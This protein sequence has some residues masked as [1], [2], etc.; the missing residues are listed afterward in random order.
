MLIIHLSK[1]S[2]ALHNPKGMRLRSESTKRTS[3][4]GLLLILSATELGENQNS[5]LSKEE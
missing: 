4:G 5:H 1:S 2:S 3:E